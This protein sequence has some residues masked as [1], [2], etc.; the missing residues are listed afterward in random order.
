MNCNPCSDQFSLDQIATSPAPL[1]ERGGAPRGETPERCVLF[2]FLHTPSPGGWTVAL[3]H[4]YGY[5]Q[6]ATR[7]TL[8]K[9]CVYASTEFSLSLYL[10]RSGWMVLP[11]SL[12]C[13]G[14]WPGPPTPHN[15]RAH[16]LTDVVRSSRG[17]R[18]RCLCPPPLW[19][20]TPKDDA[21]D[22]KL[23]SL[24]GRAGSPNALFLLYHTQAAP[25]Q[26]LFFS[27]RSPAN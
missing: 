10:L 11:L 13:G 8:N 1:G 20:S 15:A 16:G 17:S 27:G 4:P 2:I 9:E 12:P 21:N 6:A 19:T 22:D 26:V 3:R 14:P 24:R 18:L 25:R 5:D 7:D 23:F